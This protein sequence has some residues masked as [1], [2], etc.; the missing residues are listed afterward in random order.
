MAFFLDVCVWL[1]EGQRAAQVLQTI[2]RRLSKSDVRVHGW[3]GAQKY[4]GDYGTS[5]LLCSDDTT[6]DR[7]KFILHEDEQQALQSPANVQQQA[8]LVD[9][10]GWL[11]RS[12]GEG[13]R[14]LP[15]G[16]GLK[17]QDR[18]FGLPSHCQAMEPDLSVRI[19]GIPSISSL[20]MTAA[21]MKGSNDLEP[22]VA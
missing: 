7:L 17:V 19:D 9:G 20:G 8:F 10:A 16:L 11:D 6:S 22:S 3:S 12:T 18:G 1:P 21:H 5:Q 4:V 15:I 14:S 2:L 13:T